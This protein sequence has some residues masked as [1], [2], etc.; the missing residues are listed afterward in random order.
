MTRNMCKNNEKQKW[1]IL[2][3]HTEKWDKPFSEIN[4]GTGRKVKPINL[5]NNFF[6]SI[7]SRTYPLIHK[8]YDALW[9]L[10]I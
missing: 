8:V 4:I 5:V 10:G 6:S 7:V 9:I 3:T 1:A 2:R